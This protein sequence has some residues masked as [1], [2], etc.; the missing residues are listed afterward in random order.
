MKGNRMSDHAVDHKPHPK[1]KVTIAQINPTV[2]DILANCEKILALFYEADRRGQ[3]L[4]VTPEL[5]LTG[6]P[7]ED[8]A[9][10]P[11]LQEA[12]DAALEKIRRATENHH[13]AILVGTPY[14]CPEGLLNAAVFL[15]DGKCPG[16]ANKRN[17]PQGSVLD[18][19]RTFSPGPIRHL[20]IKIHGVNVGV[21]L[22]EDAEGREGSEEL[23]NLGAEVIICLHADPF[24]PAV[25][26]R[27]V[28]NI[29][30]NRVAES[31]LPFLFVNL[32]GGQDEVVFDGG[33]FGLDHSGR[34]FVQ[35][36]QWEE[37]VLDCD[38]GADNPPLEG[39]VFPDPLEEGW[40]GMVLALGDY[41]RKSGFT[42]VLLGLSGGL[43]SAVVAAVAGDALGSERV[44][45]LRLPGQFTSD[46]SNNSAAA[47]AK[48]WGFTLDTVPIQPVVTAA[49]ESL[50][51]FQPEGLKKLTRENLQARARGYLL[52]TISNER[53]WLLLSTGNKSEIAVGYATLYGDMC[54]GFCPLKDVFKTNVFKLAKWRNKHRPAG[55]KGPEGLVIPTEIIE[56]PPSAE[57]SD[58]QLDSDS[59][60]PYPLLD[61]ILREF[62]EKRLPVEAIA[63]MGYDPEMVAKV[64]RMLRLSEYKRR[65]GAP[66]PKLSPRAFTHDRRVPIVNHFYPGMIAKI[67]GE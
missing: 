27:R 19:S 15:Q 2:G 5:A 58:G 28:R 29:A 43:D 17:L 65:Q 62:V 6:C 7:L 37:K 39:E 8:L 32:V 59:L 22:G 52:M 35:L 63:G 50:R 24:H 1:L 60:P 44:H 12:C 42:D 47:M 41:V 64:H 46:L 67:R 21:L 4:F 18:Q 54:G 53:G 45:C 13:C 57:L 51:D 49:M 26:E 33:S 16:L 31:G 56:R 40:R 48:I 11:D 36:P 38:L 30:A 14:I 20:P 9:A 55:L 61:G 3:D 23:V 25:L 34:R 10:T 66:G